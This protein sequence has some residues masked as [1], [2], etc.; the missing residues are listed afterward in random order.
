MPCS[1]RRRRS[2]PRLTAANAAVATKESEIAALKA[3]VPGLQAA[4]SNANAN[5][6]A[7][8]GELTLLQGQLPAL[9]GAAATAAAN[10]STQHTGSGGP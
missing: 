5:V 1:S 2:R 9:Q 7:K 10:V 4:V 8:Q 3:Q 6:T